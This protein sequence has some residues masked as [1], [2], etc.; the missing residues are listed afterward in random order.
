M[1]TRVVLLVG[2][3]LSGCVEERLTR[4]YA[5]LLPPGDGDGRVVLAV[6]D[7]AVPSPD[8]R[9]RGLD[10]SPEAQ[11]SLVA[12]LAGNGS[13]AADI[14]RE[15]AVSHS[16]EGAADS[17]SDATDIKR[18]LVLTVGYPPDMWRSTLR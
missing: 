17:F 12:S 11:A 14:V 13:K 8:K 9:A 1:K 15:L 2:V 5:R 7:Q 10:L 4:R 3:L 6:S 16:L 18:R